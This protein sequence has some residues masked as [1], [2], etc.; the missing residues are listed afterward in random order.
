MRFACW[1]AKVSDVD[2][3]YVIIFIVSRLQQWLRELTSMLRY[4]YIACRVNSDTNALRQGVALRFVSFRTL[5]LKADSSQLQAPTVLYD[6]RMVTMLTF[7]VIFEYF[8]VLEISIRWNSAQVF[9]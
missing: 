5:A 7:E 4:T 8:L 1:I 3:E 2:S 9:F 6:S